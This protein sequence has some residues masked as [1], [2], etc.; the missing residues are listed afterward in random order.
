[1]SDS[2]KKFFAAA[3][4]YILGE[5]PGVKLSGTSEKLKAT[6][7]ALTASRE[8]YEALNDPASGMQDI[9]QLLETKHR[10]AAQFEKETGIRWIL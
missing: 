4:S 1:M 5:K 7:G 8:L 10:M 6:Q 9:A 3:A 2:R